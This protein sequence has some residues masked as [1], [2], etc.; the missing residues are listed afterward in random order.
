MAVRT[1]DSRVVVTVG[2]MA[3]SMADM[4]AGSKAVETAGC[5][6]V[7]SAER[8]ERHLADAMAAT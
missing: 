5:S 4:K 2:S 7:P 3:V 6:A 1:A 8:L